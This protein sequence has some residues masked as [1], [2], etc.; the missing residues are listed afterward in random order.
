MLWNPLFL[1]AI[2]GVAVTGAIVGNIYLWDDDAE[3]TPKTEQVEAA[4]LTKADPA[5]VEKLETQKIPNP[6][7]PAAIGS[8]N[9]NPQKVVEQAAL[10]GAQEKIE[11]T[12]PQTE[13]ATP[14][15]FDVVRITPDG[16]AVVAGRAKPG[17]RVVILDNG[18]FA[19]QLD[20]DSHGEW[21]FVPEKPFAPGSRQLGLE[22]HIEGQ[23]PVASDDVVVLVVPEPNKDIAGRKTD[24][25]T[26]SLA[27]K[28]PKKG[29]VSTVLQ[30]PSGDP[31]ENIL[32][33]ETVDY[34]ESGRLLISGRAESTA[35]VFVYLDNVIAGKVKANSDG[36]WQMQPEQRVDPG[37][38]TLRA[39][40]VKSDG[41][42]LARISMPFSRAEPMEEMPSEPFVIVQP[43]NSLWRIARST[44][45]SGFGFTTIYEANKDQIQNPDMIF[46]GQVFALPSGNL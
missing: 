36:I 28:F 45:G 27:L 4:P 23:E 41:S 9:S 44:Y 33:V 40:Q 3:L 21:V 31:G 25:P 42:V 15:S 30:K 13:N 6:A 19:G 7:K 24:K 35:N 34:D 46:P 8:E 32:S 37:I 14:P 18:Q 16:N 20:T 29:G 43:G 26:Q 17:S 2:G 5:P 11:N 10:P 39:D 1:A 22:M 38:Y 12:Q